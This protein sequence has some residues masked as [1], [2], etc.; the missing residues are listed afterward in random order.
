MK[1]YLGVKSW[2]HTAFIQKNISDKITVFMLDC[3]LQLHGFFWL[4]QIEFMLPGLAQRPFVIS[5]K[6][7]SSIAHQ[8]NL[9]LWQEQFIKDPLKQLHFRRFLPVTSLRGVRS[10]TLLAESSAAPPP[11]PPA[12]LQ[13]LQALSCCHHL[14]L[15]VVTTRPFPAESNNILIS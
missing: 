11:P 9:Q 13:E 6:D 4:Y 15:W 1:N 14:S 8:N 12:V 5:P 10:R 2:I 7:S 3:S